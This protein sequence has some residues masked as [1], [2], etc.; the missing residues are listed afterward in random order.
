MKVQKRIV[1]TTSDLKKD[2]KPKT[3]LVNFRIEDTLYR[4]FQQYCQSE[5][6]TGVSD[7]LRKVIKTLCEKS[8]YL[9]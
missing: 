6:E 7:V 8:G 1:I 2:L 9:R 5:L 4:T 3:T